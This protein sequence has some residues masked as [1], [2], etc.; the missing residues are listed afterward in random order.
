MAGLR[1]NGAARA[2][3]RNELER[4][5]VALRDRSTHEKRP[6]KIRVLRRALGGL[7]VQAIEF[8]GPLF[9]ARDFALARDYFQ[10]AVAADPASAWALQNLAAAQAQTGDRKAAFE[11]LRRAREQTKDRAAFSAWLAKEESFV[12]LRQDPQFRAL[13][14]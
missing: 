9:D 10:L 6:E 13:L 8:G 12:K 5:I 14:D 11:S 7:L 3:L 1:D 4:K 2:D